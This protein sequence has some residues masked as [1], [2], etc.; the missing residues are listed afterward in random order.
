LNPAHG[1]GQLGLHRC[2]ELL[3]HYLSLSKLLPFDN[4]PEHVPVVIG[5]VEEGNI[6]G[7][8]QV[9]RPSMPCVH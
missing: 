8:S 3:P 4:R 2:P 5:R 7:R 9:R 1:F 6:F